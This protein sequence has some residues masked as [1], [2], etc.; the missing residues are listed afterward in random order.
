MLLALLDADVPGRLDALVKQG[1]ISGV[2]R[3]R[4]NDAFMRGHNPEDALVALVEN[5]TG[6]HRSA[7]SRQVDEKQ[8]Q[9]LR[10]GYVI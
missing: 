1:R 5:V 3:D 9:M 4:F 2:M 8:K 10:C 6:Q 7:L